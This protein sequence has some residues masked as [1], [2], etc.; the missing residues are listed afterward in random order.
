MFLA[1]GSRTSRS[2]NGSRHRLNPRAHGHGL[3]CVQL[4]HGLCRH[5]NRDMLDM[6]SDEGLVQLLGTEPLLPR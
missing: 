6:Q 1:R 3:E 4:Y 5:T 2:H